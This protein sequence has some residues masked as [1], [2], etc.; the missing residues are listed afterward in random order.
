MLL[1]VYCNGTL[2]DNLI[3]TNSFSMLRLVIHRRFV[4]T[5]VRDVKSSNDFPSKLSAK[6]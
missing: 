3:Y 6:A 2:S 1:L 5:T 4:K